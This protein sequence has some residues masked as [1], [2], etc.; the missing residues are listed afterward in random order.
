MSTEGDLA[1]LVGRRADRR[2]LD[3]DAGALPASLGVPPE[4]AGASRAS[5]RLTVLGA[6]FTGASL[7]GGIALV[8]IAVVLLI[9]GAPVAIVGGAMVL[10]LLLAGTHWGWAHVAEVTA[11]S[12]ERRVQAGAEMARER[13]LE[14]IEP[15][16]RYEVVT[17]VDE[18][19]AIEIV[20]YAYRPIAVGENGFDFE[21]AV[22]SRERHSG[23]EPGAQ[24][25]ER[26]ELLRHQAAAQTARRRALYEQTAQAYSVAL[27]TR[28]D[29]Q[30]RLQARRAAAQ[31]LSE[32][33]NRNLREPP[34]IE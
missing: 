16:D 27:A 5:R 25:A 9:A 23:D 30:A 22:L 18:D 24:V 33:I 7:M 17:E 1:Q 34:L 4:P 19:G 8:V 32:A 2:L 10:G 11:S 13:W 20:S 12:L 15:Y 26:A 14:A 21:R 28:D 31:A 6:T 29:E 3:R